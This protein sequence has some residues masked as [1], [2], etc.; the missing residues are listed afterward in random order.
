MLGTFPGA[1]MA[2]D[3]SGRIVAAN[4]DAVRLFGW[5]REELLGR[6][7]EALISPPLRGRHQAHR[8]RYQREPRRRPMGYPGLNLSSL[9]KDG[10]EVLVDVSLAP[11]ETDDGIMTIASFCEIPERRRAEREREGLLQQLE[12]ERRWLD[13]VLQCPPVGIILLDMEGYSVANRYASGLLPEGEVVDDRR[14]FGRYARHTDGRPIADHDLPGPRALRGEVVDRE[15]LLVQYPDGRDLTLLMSAAPMR[16]AVGQILGAVV[17]FMDISVIRRMERSRE[18]WIS[19][20]AHDLRQ[21]LNHLQ[22]AADML[23]ARKVKDVPG[24]IAAMRES[25]R[26]LDHMITDLLDASLLEADRLEVR[27]DPVDVTQLVRRAVERIQLGGAGAAGVELDAPTEGCPALADAERLEQVV[28]N[29]VSNAVKYRYEGTPVRIGI[30][31]RDGQIHV[32]VANEGEGILPE[33]LGGLF[34]RFG[35]TRRARAG[36]ISGIGLG[37]YIARGLVEAHGGRLWAESVPG[38]TTT[39]HFMLPAIPG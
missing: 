24:S 29:L 16:D 14:P 15:E 25:I 35:R 2:V 38:A 30:E 5:T 26:W 20:V 37:L 4:D 1:A 28:G 3:G 7:V 17:A 13:T 32:S 21:P 23:H 9:R 31:R 12:Q 19:I 8:D 18:E 36:N 22:L 27:K 39:F 10:A 33:D 34:H 11:L 6:S